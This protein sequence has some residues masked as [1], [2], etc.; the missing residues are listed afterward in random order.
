VRVSATDG[1][2]Q[3]GAVEEAGVEEVGGSAAG[4]QGVNAE[5]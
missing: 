2:Q 3:R 1:A 4:F 5:C